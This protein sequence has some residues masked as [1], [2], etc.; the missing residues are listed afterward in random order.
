MFGNTIEEVMDLQKDRFPYRKLPWIQVTLSQQVSK[1]T[2]PPSVFIKTFFFRKI[3]RSFCI[4]AVCLCTFLK[5]L[6]LNGTQTEGIFRVSADVDEVNYWKGRLDRWDVP[7][8][9]STMGE[10][11][12]ATYLLLNCYC[13]IL[14]RFPIFFLFKLPDA[15]AP[16]SCLKLW[17]RELYDPLIPDELYDECV[18]TEDPKIALAIV[19]RLPSFNKMVKFCN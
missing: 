14:N 9:K 16:A 8:H 5:V 13:T 18:S 7:E 4:F 15:H 10:S 6:M 17:Y 3:K 19:D 11:S 1:T 12:V 2:Q